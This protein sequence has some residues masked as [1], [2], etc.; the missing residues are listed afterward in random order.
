[1]SAT[2]A[3]GELADLLLAGE[4]SAVSSA[5][6]EAGAEPDE[7]VSGLARELTRRVHMDR[8]AA[9][10]AAGLLVG[11]ADRWCGP[12]GRARA[13]V[14]LAHALNYADRLEDALRVLDGGTLSWWP[15]LPE[16]VVAEVSLARVHALARLA[17][18]DEAAGEAERAQGA[19]AR[20]AQ[21][22]LAAKALVNLGVVRRMQERP[23]DALACLTAA[24]AVL[25]ADAPAAAQIESNRAHALLDLER[26]AESTRAFEASRDAFALAGLERAAAIADGN[27]GDAY[28]RM[29]RLRE[30]IAAYERAAA[31]LDKSGDQS[32]R[33]RLA[34]E[35]AEV[36][37]RLGLLGEAI[38]AFAAALPT[39]TSIGLTH[40]AARA[41]LGMAQAY[42]ERGAD[43]LAAGAAARAVRAFESLN[44]GRGLAQTLVVSARLA[45][46]AGRASEATGHVERACALL[47]DRPVALGTAR[48]ALAEAKLMEGDVP[49][50]LGLA[51]LLDEQASASGLSWSELEAARTRAKVCLACGDRAGALRAYRRAINAA[52][53]LRHALGAEWLRSAFVGSQAGLFDE[54]IAAA[55]G[56]AGGDAEAVLELCEAHSSRGLLD[57][58]TVGDALLD[59]WRGRADGG[60]RDEAGEL[61]EGVLRLR[62]IYDAVQTRD[63]PGPGWLERAARA[64]RKLQ[65]AELRVSALSPGWLSQRPATTAELMGELGEAEALLCTVPA[66]GVWHAVVVRATG[67]RLVRLGEVEAVRS[68]GARLGFA[69]RRSVAMI[70]SGSALSSGAV[71]CE[72]ALAELR[73][74]LVRAELVEALAGVRSVVVVPREELFGLPWAA[75]LPGGTAV[76]VSP[77]ASVWHSLRTRE[78]AG[79]RGGGQGAGRRGVLVCGVSDGLAPQMDEEARAVAR[80]IGDDEPL[81]GE[82]ATF[83][84]F[85]ARAAGAG[86]IHLACHGAFAED[87]PM[88]AR[89]RFSD[90]TVTARELLSLELS[91]AT[92]VLSGC[93]TVA[94]GV[95]R[96][97][98][99]LGTVRALLA[100][101]AARVVGSLWPVVDRAAC[102]HFEQLHA[103]GEADV[104]RGLSIAQTRWREAGESAA[105]WAAYAVFG[106]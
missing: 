67:A 81:L 11:L 32:E 15:D 20:S 56:P 7:V 101:G 8:E 21:P 77:S 63:D 62:A 82:G 54:A 85:A 89:L 90:R 59:R 61:I 34:C 53:R 50:A 102:A 69:V 39:L 76:R 47:A 91:G 97:N 27:L 31:A 88:Q 24:L 41:W 48:A 55:T 16:A 72:R 9:E 57:L 3:I 52:E 94:I 26:Y 17:R 98:E 28:R 14:A 45:L 71:A 38:D 74:L 100:A 105:V 23:E 22:Q 60:R 46:R 13:R 73:G 40:E 95:S 80:A 37:A 64:E 99:V 68:A 87:V 92:V 43:D 51:A 70:A 49:A 25:R 36:L 75:L 83:E 5:L 10:R 29:G 1:M 106:V 104:A 103:G 93:E 6:L 66:H 33:A 30:A 96:G 19:F 12:A 42:A 79:A 2:L 65:E 84:A 35:R 78:R 86:L 58:V 18:L 44:A 4:A